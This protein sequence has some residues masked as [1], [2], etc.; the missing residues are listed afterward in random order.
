MT[1]DNRLMVVYFVKG[2]NSDGEPVAENR[3]VELSADGEHGTSVVLP[4][5]QPFSD[6]FT[7]TVRGGSKTSQVIDMLGIQDGV[8]NAVPYARIRIK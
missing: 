4:L 7:A 8:K 2:T 6:F 3:L 1:P 5:K